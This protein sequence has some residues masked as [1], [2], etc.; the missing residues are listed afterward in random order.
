MLGFRSILAVIAVGFLARPSLQQQTCD[1][2]VNSAVVGVSGTCK[3]NTPDNAKGTF[4]MVSGCT[5]MVT[6]V[7]IMAGVPDV[8]IWATTDAAKVEENGKRISDVR[9]DVKGL[10]DATVNFDLLPSIDLSKFT[11]VVMWCE[12]FKANLADF[13][14]TAAI[15]GVSSAPAPSTSSSSPA[16][17]Q[18][19]PVTTSEGIQTV[20]DVFT[21][22]VTLGSNLNYPN[23]PGWGMSYRLNGLESPV[24]KAVRGKKYTFNVKA[25][26]SHP[27]YITSSIIGGKGNLDG[28]N[29]TVYAGGA[30]GVA[31]TAATPGVLEWTPD[32]S[33]PD[34][35]YYQCF[36]HQK[37]GWKIMVSDDKPASSAGSASSSSLSQSLL[38]VTVIL[39]QK[40]LGSEGP[41]STIPAQ[42]GYT[43]D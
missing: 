41:K 34:A 22:D 38:A 1:P 33:T 27:L 10:Q 12:T 15:K 5:F 18:T 42:C 24:I 2:S 3:T 25:T 36:T 30:A 31:G 23:P 21:F 17:I 43:K 39:G 16:P 6:G 26:A 37:L 9:L 20:S 28:S 4:K 35:V 7:S 13:D 19:A 40:V 32:K 14:L 8:H 29:E 11:R